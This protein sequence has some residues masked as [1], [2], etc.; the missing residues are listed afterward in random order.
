MLKNIPDIISPELMKNL[1]E[2]GHSDTLVICDGNYPAYTMNDNV[3]PA[4][5]HSVN[6][7]LK[8]I[9]EFFPL[10]TYTDHPV[11]LMQVVE[12][13][14]T[15][16]VVWNDF[17]ETI[18]K[19]GYDEEK[20]VTNIDRFDFYDQSKGAYLFIATTDRALYANVMLQ[21]GVC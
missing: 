13:D 14:P 11:K 19:A 7:V 2:M 18:K 15:V 5:G 20:V 3:I 9:L 4:Y 16:P 21:K 6:D 10:D 8:A 17:K 12:G 1:M